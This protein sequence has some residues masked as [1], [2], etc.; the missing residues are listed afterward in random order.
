MLIPKHT[1]TY[2]IQDF[3]PN[4]CSVLMLSILLYNIEGKLH[5]KHAELNLESTHK[6]ELEKSSF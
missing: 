1:V 5:Q 2:T 3:H 6:S 4:T